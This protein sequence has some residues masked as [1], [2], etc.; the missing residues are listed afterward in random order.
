MP[1]EVVNKPASHEELVE[2]VNFFATVAYERGMITD[3][4]AFWRFFQVEKRYRIDLRVVEASDGISIICR[5]CGVTDYAS[6]MARFFAS[7]PPE[8]EILTERDTKVPPRKG[9]SKINGKPSK[10]QFAAKGKG[11]RPRR[12]RGVTNTKTEPIPTIFDDSGYGSGSEDGNSV[13]VQ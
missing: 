3:K 11:K 13:L 5:L 10:I 8:S 1:T 4:K 2:L 9:T 12:A 7:G 6:L